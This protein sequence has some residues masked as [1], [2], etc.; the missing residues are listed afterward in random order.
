MDDQFIGNYRILKKVGAGGMA[1]VYLA[2]HRDV[3]NLKVVLKVLSDPRLVERFK[4]EADKLALLDGNAN[5]CQ[6]KHFF[7]HGDDIVIAMEYID[8]VTLED[9][10]VAEKRLPIDKSLQ[11]TSEVLGTLDFAHQKKIFH[12]DIKPGNIML[13]GKGQTKI[14]DFGIA[15]SDTD[16]HLTIA[17]GAC[18]TPTYMAPEQ[19]NPT[20]QVNYALTDVYAVG[21]MLFYMLTGKLPFEGD[22]P[23]LLRDAKLSSEPPKP[24][25]LNP[26]ISKELENIILKAMDKEPEKRFAS[27]SQM[28]QEIDSLRRGSPKEDK[29]SHRPT[30]E[31]ES[32]PSTKK[33]RRM[34]VPLLVILLAVVVVA[35]YMNIGKKSTPIPTVMVPQLY[36]PPAE[37]VLTDNAVTFEWEATA[38]E[39]GSYILE[40][41]NN[42]EFVNSQISPRLT[43]NGYSPAEELPN[44]K[45]FWRVK[46][47]GSS[48]H[49]S[50]FSSA[51]SFTIAVSEKSIPLSEMSTGALE[52]TVRPQGN[53]YIDNKVRGQQEDRLNL[54]LDTGRH[55]IRVE[56]SNSIEKTLTD[57]VVI[58]AGSKLSRNFRFTFPL[59][60]PSVTSSETLVEVRIG[61]LP[62]HGGNVYID[63]VLNPLPTNN[64]YKLTIGKHI[65][66]VTLKVNGVE[67]QLVDTVLIEANGNY[68]FRFDFEKAIVLSL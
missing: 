40:Y 21:T 50:A 63:G 51:V 47:I 67:S 52:I 57:N 1:K 38:G 14:I 42:P 68:K 60:A 4:Q 35:V 25:S 31:A 28:Q 18:G 13:D 39:S 54:T 37:A 24:R 36:Q 61:S 62:T 55:T 26:D 6:I 46:S 66:A 43:R 12:R 32:I 34:T 44:G 45:Y 3:P 64:T 65:I 41:A 30:T 23:F 2:V 48:G 33:S 15:K 16:P 5:I 17:G 10:I 29:K 19:F 8:G 22:N 53:I 7:N 56:N 58:S 59:P 49:E 11:I 20:D 27:A 9:I